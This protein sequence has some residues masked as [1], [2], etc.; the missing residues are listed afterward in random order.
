MKIRELKC[1]NCDADLKIEDGVDTFYC[2]YCGSKIVL[3]GQSESSVEAK[4]RIRELEYQERIKELEQERY[5]LNMEAEKH[6]SKTALKGK[7]AAFILTGIV[8]IV[9]LIMIP[10]AAAWINHKNEIKKLEASVDEIQQEIKAGEYDSALIKTNML[11]YDSGWSEEAEKHWNDTR[12]YLVDVIE[13]KIRQKKEQ[14]QQADLAEQEAQDALKEQTAQRVREA[15]GKLNTE[16]AIDKENLTDEQYA[17]VNAPTEEYVIQ[18]L[19]KVKDIDEIVAVTE[20]TDV[21]QQLNKA[22]GYTAAVFFSSGLVDKERLFYSDILDN[23]TDGG[24]CLE[25]YRTVEDA[26][27]REAYLAMFDGSVI[28]SGSHTV[29]GTVLVRTSS[30]LKASEQKELEQNIIHVLIGGDE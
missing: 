9:A 11:Y 15:L 4:L 27:K 10:K 20:E 22:G 8:V 14:E 25:V 12:T 2:E 18:C 24:G 3:E 30:R 26:K 21:N 5:R 17:L 23:G 29:V 19:E 7:K 16:E 1:P 28:S 13:T 6:K